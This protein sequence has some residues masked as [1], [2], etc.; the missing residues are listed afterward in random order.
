MNARALF[1]LPWHYLMR[2]LL[3]TLRGCQE[4]CLSLS[5]VCLDAVA[6]FDALIDA[7]EDRL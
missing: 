4:A 5:Q 1:W 6:E 3:A 2:G 7:V